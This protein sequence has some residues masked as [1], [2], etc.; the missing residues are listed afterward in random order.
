L[1]SPYIDLVGFEPTWIL[2]LKS[3]AILGC[4]QYPIG[5]SQ[6]QPGTSLRKAG[7]RV[8]LSKR[9]VGATMAAVTDIGNLITSS[10]EIRGGRA[11]VAGTGVTVMRIAGWYKLGC[12]PEEIARKT[13]LSLAQIH[14]ALAYYHTDQDRIDA[15]LD[16][17]AEEY[18]RLALEHRRDPQGDAQRQ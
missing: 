10:P 3:W 6:F 17:E 7:K 11:R 13:G 15:D 5:I 14:A 9:I 2:S 4:P 16:A 18:D 12:S 1:V 8:S